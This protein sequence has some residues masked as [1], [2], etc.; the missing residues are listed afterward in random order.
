MNE[1]NTNKPDS[2][3]EELHRLTNMPDDEIDTSDIPE[4]TDWSK[5]ERGKFY[6]A[7]AEHQIPLYVD[8]KVLEFLTTRARDKGIEPNDL[9][10]E[11]LKRDIESIR[12]AE[13]G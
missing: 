12:S 10:N 11:M 2:V 4:I 1:G 7:D 13:P 9:V 5:G 3:D 6:R 8:S